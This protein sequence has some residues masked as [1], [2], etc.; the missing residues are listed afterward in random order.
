VLGR[1]SSEVALRL[2]GKHMDIFT[3]HVDTCD[4]IV[5]FNAAKLKVTGTT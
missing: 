2:R 5:I 1:V 3:P 4:Y